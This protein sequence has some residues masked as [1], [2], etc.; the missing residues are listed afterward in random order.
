MMNKNNESIETSIARERL[1]QAQYSF[2]LALVMTAAFACMSLM[3]IGL[4]LQGKSTEGVVS[5]TGGTI[6][7]L[8][9]LKIAK[10]ANDR[11]D[12]LRSIRIGKE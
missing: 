7:S 6:A 5:T 9:C 12:M 10:D 8:R 2:N 11:L 4:S 3:G 1:R